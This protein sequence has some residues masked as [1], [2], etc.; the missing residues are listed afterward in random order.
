MGLSLTP[1]RRIGGDIE[2]FLT[3]G[4]PA[5]VTPVAAPRVA[6]QP[7]AAPAPVQA[8]NSQASVAGALI[9]NP[10]GMPFGPAQGPQPLSKD[11]SQA[12][13][14]VAP[15][16]VINTLRAGGSALNAAVA[17]RTGNTV[18]F[19]N[20][21]K[22][23]TSDTKP[24]NS[25]FTSQYLNRPT[26]GGALAGA[27]TGVLQLAPFV[28]P[29]GGILGEEA[30]P[31]LKLATSAG[32][33]GGLGT[34]AS[35]ANQE[36]NTGKVS[37]KQ[38]A[39]AGGQQALSAGLTEGAHL[40]KDNQPLPAP[41][42]SAAGLRPAAIDM[43]V[44]TAKA[45]KANVAKSAETAGKQAATVASNIPGE[46][47]PTGLAVPDTTQVKETSGSTP[48]LVRE[49]PRSNTGI[50]QL[51]K[52][53]NDVAD[54]YTA[55][56]TYSGDVNSVA[57]QA[58]GNERLGNRVSSRLG[59]ALKKFLTPEEN[60]AV[61][62]FL[63]G[64]PT[65]KM[66]ATALKVANALRP[67]REQ[68]HDVRAALKTTVGKVVDYSPR[69]L[70]TSVKSAAKGA[71]K[72][73][74]KAVGKKFSTES[75]FSES[76]VN[77][78]FV[79]S[80]DTLVGNPKQLGLTD[81]GNGSFHD[82]NG[83]I[84]KQIHATKEELTQAGVGEYARRTSTVNRLYH[85]ETL[86][87]KARG[88]AVEELKNNP[89]AHGLYTQDQV[90]N[91]VAPEG[92][93]KIPGVDGLQ[94]LYASDKDATQ[95]QHRLGFSGKSTPLGLRAYDA[96]SNVATQA[97][98]LNPIFHGMNQ[99][100][101]TGLAAGNLPGMKGIP[102]HGMIAVIKAIASLN[103]DDYH[104]V[105]EHGAGGSD[106]GASMENMLSK[107]TGGATKI[108]AKTMA[109]IEL[110]FH[111][112]LYKASVEKGMKPAE[113]AEN[114]NK[115]LGDS[116]HINDSVRRA[117]LFAH[118]FKTMSKAI[119]TQVAHPIEQRGSI[120][121]AVTLASA[122]AGLS[123]GYQKLTGNKNANV[124]L[125]GELGLIKQAVGSGEALA[126]GDV[127]GGASILTNRINP[128]LKE[129]GQ[130]LFNKDLFTGQPV[131]AS[132]GGRLGH[133]ESSLLAPVATIGKVT[134][135]SR[136]P[137]ELVA[138]QLGLNTPHA[139]GYQAA[140]NAP[141]LNT[142]GSITSKTGDSTGYQQEQQYF[143]NLNKLKGQFSGDTSTSDSLSKYLDRS[144]D[145]VTGQTIQE[146]PA[147]SMENAGA[148]ATNDKLR[149]AVQSFEKSQP[150][151]DPMWDLPS[152]KLATL[153]TYRAQLEGSAE[154]T[155]LKAN[156]QN[157]S[158]NWITDIQNKENAFYDSLPKLPGA[159]G[160]EANAS[161]PAYPTFDPSTTKLMATYD[162]ATPTQKTALEQN[163]GGELSSAFNQIAQWTNQMRIAQTG[164]ATPQMASYPTASPQV[165]AI[166]NTY[167]ALPKGNGP[168]GGSPDRS[169]WITANPAAYA[170]MQSYLTK[171]SLNSLITNAAKAQFAG[172]SPDQALLKD[173]KNVGTY[174]VAT[175]T[176]PSGATAYELNP[177]MAFSQSSTSSLSGSSS[178]K[179]TKA[180][181]SEKAA[182]AIKYAAPKFNARTS[183]VSLRAP[184]PI[185]TFKVKMP[186]IGKSYKVTKVKVGKPSAKL[187]V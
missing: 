120:V 36:L 163:F 77:D 47:G 62:D 81:R 65:D 154:K 52:A 124:R 69:I 142:P 7:I 140:P 123:Y 22:A 11:L 34:A 53:I 98:V 114:I 56:K 147:D 5:P 12:Y 85:T 137:T 182:N 105:L 16:Q 121:N 122:F 109:A 83:K 90:D 130:Q 110:K 80:K 160:S 60:Q 63:D 58:S 75:G 96:L 146:S 88:A 99:L 176:T 25:L 166:M 106:Y 38:A 8:A 35:A 6:P 67:L 43:T 94:D 71:V 41:K 152:G 10:S 59:A 132:A 149:D 29:G 117:T 30:A 54:E 87:L 118:Y 55:N 95:L 125:P 175:T 108:N 157:G 18:A 57:E 9:P 1:L 156:A 21:E 50:P 27:G 3:G 111:A 171:V 23:F 20:A 113:A 141:L 173:I 165:Q 115:F 144:H 2:N 24:N 33:Y 86:G 92:V 49:V 107:M 153:M 131:T 61:E 45:P 84:Y 119:G 89:N 19:Q 138:N 101:Q 42:A 44:D 82:A 139:K 103:E 116:K 76:R 4:P 13:N 135:G 28:A 104:Q 170:Q 133:A 64:H 186:T 177:A 136:S 180:R 143:K 169:A 179:F 91:G 126:H 102:G 97:I 134:E 48:L 174:D 183:K 51:D 162:A 66:T 68:S 185:R 74:A 151:H 26:I 150:Q 79:G 148:L 70:A 14:T 187:K 129:T 40:V 181:D 172:T 31:A 46:A 159:K 37:L 100:V 161:T 39:E 184:N 164:K 145:P 167:D 72:G 168:S 15:T 93:R 73:V 155:T 128:V 32:I 17:A 112:G 127:L 158:D 78:K 178:S